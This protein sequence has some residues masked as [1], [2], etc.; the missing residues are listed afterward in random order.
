MGKQIGIYRYSGKVGEA[1]GMTGE[2]GKAYVRENKAPRNANTEKQIMQ[3]TKMS[4]AGKI[5]K[6]TAKELILGLGASTRKR[7]AEFVRIIAKSAIAERAGDTIKAKI[8]PA[9]V[10]FS[11]G[12]T[13][14]TPTMTTV[15]Q[16]NTLTAT[17]AQDSDIP[18][19]MA[20]ILVIGVFEDTNQDVVC[21][22]GDII[23]ATNLSV[24]IAAPVASGVNVYLV[25]IIKSSGASRASYE[26][27]V[28]ML[29]A[30]HSYQTAA[31]LS[32]AGTIA[33][34]TS[35]YVNHLSPSA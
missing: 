25:P 14:A 26:Q 13:V 10:K 7:R 35:T 27:A 17:V 9:L 19:N 4:L 16:N 2:D 34:A 24:A 28:E 3:R 21:V 1:V 30:D 15:L 29:N 22:D 32:T 33:Y 8:D 11:D 12:L 20:G 5:S 6:Q 23:T 31:E 18:E